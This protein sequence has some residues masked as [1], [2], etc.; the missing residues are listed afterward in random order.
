MK[1]ILLSV[2]LSII[3][4]SGF[5]S[6]YSTNS[7]FNITPKARDSL[8]RV[9]DKVIK[10]KQ[11]YSD[12]KAN[13]IEDLKSQANLAVSDEV[14][15]FIYAQLFEEYKSFQMDSALVIANK[16][17]EIAKKLG[18]PLF[19]FFSEM[20]IAN[21][22]IVT[23]MY[24][25][26]LD[27]L[28]SQ[29]RSKFETK[30]QYATLYHL[31]HSLYMVMA[32]YSFFE[33]E[34]INY[35][36]LEY[37]YKDSILSI[38]PPDNVGYN[39]VLISKLNAEKKYEESYNQSLEI[40]KSNKDNSHLI[41]MLMHN[42]SD[43]YRDQGKTD[44]V[45][46]FLT[47]SAINDLMSGVRE[48]MSLPEL[49]TILYN[50]GDIDRAYKYMKCSLEDAIKCQA[51]LRTLQMTNMVP[52]INAAYEAKM[53]QDQQLL[54][55]VIIVVILLVV[56][57]IISLFSLYKKL[58]ELAIA[59]KNLKDFNEELKLANENL[60]K[61][62]SELSDSNYIK[63][64]YIGYVFSMCSMYIDKIDRFRKKIN[65]KIKGGQVEDL[66]QQ[67]NSTSF[68][69]DEL[70]EFYKS[71]D[72]I[73]LNLYPNFVADFN[74][75]LQDNEQLIPKDGDLL[76][77]EMRIYALIRL[78]INDSV[79]IASFLHYS[80]QTIYNYRLKIRTKTKMNK[81]ELYEAILNL[82]KRMQ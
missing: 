71:F 3:V 33:K 56:G 8:F 2:L 75:L 12:R 53:K 7:G 67:T 39:L 65:R 79:K 4:F 82:G 58:K 44:E 24:E 26:A 46:F 27:L 48:Y 68:V 60:N 25:E 16:R 61:L 69:N 78:G 11:I 55:G 81:E 42:V 31:Y 41:G 74:S 10:E 52:I 6:S 32:D 19:T 38:L 50:K 76:T 59:R 66:L 37:Q 54:V 77:P 36:K 47:I 28:E 5:A 23:G 45:E 30:E 40:Y 49:A 70:K 34:K 73:F 29:E 13:H 18:S 80:P 20:D 57:L 9:L 51:R 1:K 64:E 17:T 62:N 15:F 72:S 63:E 21:V 14:R 43:I 22:M 35:R